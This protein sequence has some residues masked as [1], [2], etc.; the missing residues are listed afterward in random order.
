MGN[1]MKFFYIPIL[2]ILLCA[3]MSGCM[4]WE[5]ASE[6]EFD[7]SPRGLYILNE[8]NFQY[9]NASLSFYEPVTM[10]V[11]ADVFSRANGMKL[12]D[13]AQSMTIEGATGWIAVNNSHVVFRIDLTTGRETGRIENLPSPREV[14][15]ISPAKAYVSQLWDNRI[16][17]INPS[18][19]AVTGEIEIP[20][21]SA[22]SGSTEQMIFSNGYVYCNCWSY[23]TDLLKIDA[24]T[25]AVISRLNVGVQPQSI[26][27]D[28]NGRLWVLTDGGYAGNP[29]GNETPA[30]VEVDPVTM[31]IIRR[32]EMGPSDTPRQLTLGPDGTT[33]YWINRDIYRMAVDDTTLPSTPFIP[34]RGT[35][36]YGLTVDPVDGDV[37]VADAIDYQQPGMIYRYDAR[38]VEIDRFRAGITP[39]AFAWKGATR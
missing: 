39:G 14:C 11:T 17:I 28:G 30:L 27:L 23:Q 2:T 25:D 16:I 13:V 7:F 10:E 37:Y 34:G 12:G 1:E 15:I 32:M 6:E 22:T 26:A 35:I 24:A 38:G 18:T 29:I 21:M 4:K 33:L 20:G 9:G 36:Y 31:T 3:L 19:M 5:V 8:G